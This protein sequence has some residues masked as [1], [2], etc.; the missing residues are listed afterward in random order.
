[1]ASSQAYRDKISEASGLIQS[2]PTQRQSVLDKLKSERGY[3][4]K[5]AD[6]DKI[7][8]Q[9]LDSERQLDAQD[10]GVTQRL[11]GSLVTQAQ[12]DRISSNERQP[13]L[14]N[15]G[16]LS[17]TG[18]LARSSVD[19][20]DRELETAG[21]QFD[22]DTQMKLSGL[23]NEAGGLWNIYQAEDAQEER[24]RQEK[25]ARDTMA[26]NERA[27]QR[28]LQLLMGD[29]NGDGIPDTMAGSSG[30]K[31]PGSRVA[32]GTVVGDKRVVDW[33]ENGDPI[34]EDLP[35]GGSLQGAAD[36]YNNNKNSPT[37]WGINKNLGNLLYRATPYFGGAARADAGD[38]GG[39]SLNPIT[40]G[41]RAL[42]F[43]KKII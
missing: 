35:K 23:S 25:L 33:D 2:A 41:K 38:T 24:G 36:W 39:L 21:T 16:N 43:L 4:E 13:L 8:K 3:T 1:M 22:R 19:A 15:L 17:R 37:Q 12:R 18:Q 11:K 6:M 31:K 7:N 30:G 20:L 40:Q 27:Q 32:I 14:K 28:Q 26:A 29:L 34:L 10:E 42:N 9:I 5:T